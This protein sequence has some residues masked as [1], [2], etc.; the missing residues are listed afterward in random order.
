V[1]ARGRLVY[2]GPTQALG[3]DLDTFEQR[4]IELLTK[5]DSETPPSVEMVP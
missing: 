4:L 3:P 2:T 1:I 5:V